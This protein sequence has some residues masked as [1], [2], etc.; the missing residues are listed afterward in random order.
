M[1]HSEQITSN[2]TAQP[3]H[4]RATHADQLLQIYV[5]LG[6]RKGL[7]DLRQLAWLL[8]SSFRLTRG[9][10]LAGRDGVWGLACPFLPLYCSSACSSPAIQPHVRNRGSQSWHRS[11]KLLPLHQLD[12]QGSESKSQLD[13]QWQDD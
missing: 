12:A 2:F 4:A 7:Q 6:H 8:T 1:R 13:Q 5:K 9:S 10:G 3:G 11:L